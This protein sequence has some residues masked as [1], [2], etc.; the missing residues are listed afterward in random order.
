MWLQQYK[1]LKRFINANPSIAITDNSI[2]IPGDV[3]A[4]FYKNFDALRA[5]FVKDRLVIDLDRADA[6][7]EAYGTISKTVKQD[8]HLEEIKTSDNLKWFLCDPLNGLMRSLFDPVFDLLKGRLDV[9]SF[10]IAAET[11]VKNVFQPLFAEG[12]KRWTTLA[13]MQQLAA[14]RL[15]AIKSSGSSESFETKRGIFAAVRDAS[16]PS[17]TETDN[18]VFGGAAN[19]S[20]LV[21]E[22]IVHSRKLQGYVGFVHPSNMSLMKANS[23]NKK[24]EWLDQKQIKQDCGTSNLWS[25]MMLYISGESADDLKLV[26]DSERIAR[27]AAILEIMEEESWCYEKTI[28][29]ITRHNQ[30]LVPSLGSYVISRT[31]VDPESFKQLCPSENIHLISAGYDVSRLEPL[32]SALAQAVA[33][34]KEGEKKD[35]GNEENPAG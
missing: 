13:L 29:A 1:E 14:D 16:P 8:M 35:Q 17:M 26:A 18:L 3:R 20:F 34:S 5:G 4:E 30:V 11:T 10:G 31:E 21:P 32:V 9:N 19:G 22:A 28:G 12:Y 6:L 23:F 27:P 15:W 33:A 7:S 25:D 24:L 2:A